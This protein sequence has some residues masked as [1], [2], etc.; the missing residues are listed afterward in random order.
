MPIGDSITRGTYLAIYSDGPYKGQAIGLPNPD[1][2]GWRKILQDKLRSANVC[3]EFVGDLNYHAFGND[4]IIDPTFQPNHHGLAGF[5]NHSILSG[6]LVP[7][8][9]DV[10]DANNVKEIS[11]P[12]ITTV[13][14]KHQPDIILLMS[15][16]NG[17]DA[18]ARD[19]LITTITKEFHGHL[20][21]ASITPQKPPRNGYENVKAYN[22]SLQDIISLLQN[23]NKK[24]YFV[25]IYSA[26]TADDITDDGVHPNENGMNKIAETWFAALTISSLILF[27]KSEKNDESN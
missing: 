21:V 2:G 10:L 6:G 18:A 1:G 17:F 22:E 27:E 16:A 24:V 3:F 8:P 14:K 12:D 5:G 19:I 23:D 4:G 11:V 26:L 9:Q 15:G 20:F 7:T 13:I 25:D